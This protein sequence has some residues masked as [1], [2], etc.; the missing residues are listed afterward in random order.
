MLYHIVKDFSLY[1][2]KCDGKYVYDTVLYMTQILWFGSFVTV[3]LF[4]CSPSS[5]RILQI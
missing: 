4:D 3:E 2:G 5:V 1:P